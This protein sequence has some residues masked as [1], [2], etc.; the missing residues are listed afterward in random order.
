MFIGA[1][2]QNLVYTG[3]I[4]WSNRKEPVF[5]FP[6]TSVAFRFTGDVLK[7]HVKNKNEYWNNYLG[8]I[9]DGEQFKFELPKEGEGIIEIPVEKSGQ[10]VHEALLFKRQDACHEMSFC[11]IEL[12]EAGELR[13]PPVKPERRIEVYGDSVSAGEVN[14]AVEYVAKEDPEHSGEYSNAWYSYAWMTARKLN[15][16]IH[17]IAQGGIALM[18]H[19]GW[20]KEPDAIGMEYAWDK[21]HYNPFL[22]SAS[23]WDF[24]L[25]TPDV[26]IVAIGQNDNHPVDYMKE[27]YEDERAVKWRAHYKEFL[28][29]LRAQYPDA[30]IVCCT[31]VLMHDANWDK[32]IGQVVAELA[33]E[34]ITQFQYKRNGAATPGH[35]RIPED[36]EMATELAA[37]IETLPV[38]N[39]K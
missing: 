23:L 38:E 35:P 9:L 14:E 26:V 32:S 28:K 21:V 7:V 4:D 5:V 10:E 33:D 8:C 30:Q 6:C 15:A 18:N 34:K 25:Y 17:D 37:Y 22:G 12:A 13:E 20:Y 11:G 3:R 2:H 19:T 1:E 29:K 24:S 31:T 39:W 36:E 27:N 16:Q